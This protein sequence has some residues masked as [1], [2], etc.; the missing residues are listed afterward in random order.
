[1]SVA[2]KN[3]CDDEW[4]KWKSEQYAT[5]L[6]KDI[7]Q[8]LYDAG[9]TQADIGKAMGT[10]QKVICSFMKRNNMT[11]RIPTKRNQF[12]ENNDSWRGDDA[13]Y[14]AFHKR[15]EAVHG[16]PC[17]CAMCGTTDAD[18][19][20]W[21]NLTGKYHDINDYKR[22]CRKCHRQYDNSRRKESGEKQVES[23]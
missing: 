6:N 19:Y 15:V 9:M 21:A 3:R 7:V 23:P 4:R 12:R 11:S 8:S 14:S 17:L 13:G 20:D 1:M 18:W 2:A 16:K 22:M 10:S 5:K